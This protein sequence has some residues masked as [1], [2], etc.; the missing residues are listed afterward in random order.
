MTYELFQPPTSLRFATRRKKDLVRYH[1]W[2]IPSIPTRIEQLGCAV[3]ESG[4]APAWQAD[5]SRQSIA[6]LG[7][8]CSRAVTVRDRTA[9]EMAAIAALP[10]TISEPSK[11]ELTEWSFS[12]GADSGIYFAECLR[13]THHHLSW[14]QVR[15]DPRNMNYG[16]MVVTGFKTVDLNPIRISITFLYG[17]ARGSRTGGQLVE[18][19]DY[20]SARA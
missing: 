8:W 5:H 10:I 7:D 4:E 2:F 16:Q 20:W 13:R 17:I 3:A 12:I 6:A 15:K 9:E 11:T 19:F 18:L 1:D 14:S